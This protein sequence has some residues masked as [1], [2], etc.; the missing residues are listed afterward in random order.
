MGRDHADGPC[1]SN[2]ISRR[3]FTVEVELSVVFA[4]SI[5][6]S[7]A[8]ELADDVSALARL[9]DCLE[10]LAAALRGVPFVPSMHKWG[11]SCLQAATQVSVTFKYKGKINEYLPD[12]RGCASVRLMV[13]VG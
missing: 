1:F 3:G 6:C 9:E 5:A 8:F 2:S 12:F 10:D 13:T 7:S 11:V 4:L